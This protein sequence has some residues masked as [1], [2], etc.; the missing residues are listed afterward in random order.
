MIILNKII[1]W[2]LDKQNRQLILFVVILIASVLFLKECQ[3]VSKLKT[4]IENG[5]IDNA[6][7]ERNRLA[8]TDSLKIEYDKKNK[9]YTT[10]KAAFELTKEELET[11]Y[12][13]LFDSKTLNSLKDKNEKVISV[14]KENVII[15]EH[16]VTNNVFV[17]DSIL[18]GQ[19]SFNSDTSF[20]LGNSRKVSGILNYKKDSNIISSRNVILDIS[21]QME[22]YTGLNRNK[23]SGQVKIWAKTKYPGITFSV[24]EG[25]SIED[26]KLTKETIASFRKPWSLGASFGVGILYNTKQQNITPGIFMGIGVNYS[27]K[28]LQFGK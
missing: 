19:F 11:K 21:Q 14:T 8:E 12:K 13:D 10:S 1:S 28:K 20:S 9:L 2:C 27:P 15:K 22:I 6:R 23:K 26:D 18:G 5:K 3:K 24:L 7:I 16:I 17:K 4:E 25:A